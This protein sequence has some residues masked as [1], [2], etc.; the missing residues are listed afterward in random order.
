MRYIAVTAALGAEQEIADIGPSPNCVID[1]IFRKGGAAPFLPRAA[2]TAPTETP[3]ERLR[4]IHQQNERKSKTERRHDAK[5]LHC[6]RDL[7]HKTSPSERGDCKSGPKKESMG[8]IS[9]SI[10]TGRSTVSRPVWSST[11][12]TLSRYI[13]A[14]FRSSEK[15]PVLGRTSMSQFLNQ[16]ACDREVGRKMMFRR[17]GRIGR[18]FFGK[19]FG[20]L[21]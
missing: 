7:S 12:C 2:P 18:R 10:V 17:Q 5:P 4:G 9:A 16:E 11:G 15:F 3:Y 1:A 20:R 6:G 13:S 19:E 14:Y 21:S 8:E